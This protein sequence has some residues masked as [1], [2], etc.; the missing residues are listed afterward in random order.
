[1]ALAAPAGPP[2]TIRTSVFKVD[3]FSL[4]LIT[5]LRKLF[6]VIEKIFH[7]KMLALGRAFPC[8]GTAIAT[9]L[10]RLRYSAKSNDGPVKN[11]VTSAINTIMAKMLGDRMP[12]S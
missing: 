7:T 4:P 10:R 3:T 6:C 2:P 9:A 12:R 11:V 5:S 1:M 8:Y